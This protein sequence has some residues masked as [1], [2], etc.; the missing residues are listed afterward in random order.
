VR[1]LAP[2]LL[3]SA[4][5]AA[6]QDPVQKTAAPDEATQKTALAMIADVYKPDYEKAKSAPQKVELAKKLLGVGVATEDDPTSRF[7]LF[8]IARDIASQQ[9]DLSTA[10]DA[11]RHIEL[12]FIADTLQMKVDAATVALKSLETPRD[13]LSC[14]VLL[15]AQLDD[16]VFADRYEL[17]KSLASSMLKCARN[18]RDAECIKQAVAIVKMLDD[19]AAEYEKVR[20]AKTA[21]DEQPA[22]PAANFALATFFC[23]VKGNW[24]R[25]V[26]MFALGAN[27]E[28]KAAA[29]LELEAK[30]DSVK[31]GDAWWRIA[32]GLEGT[33]KSKTQIHAVAWYRRALPQLS[34]FSKERVERLIAQEPSGPDSLKIRLTPSAT[35]IEKWI[36]GTFDVVW[37]ES[38]TGKSGT[39]RCTYDSKGGVFRGSERNGT[40]KLK[41]DAIEIQFADPSR[42]RALVKPIDA[43][44][45]TGTHRMGDGN[46][47]TWTGKRVK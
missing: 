12:A 13:H 10:F 33:A 19:I 3:M 35:E 8:R 14:A 29:L 18:S 43:N 23:F 11:I 25:G 22:D 32:E 36:V 27:E 26:P 20:G 16:A 37:S 6:A 38:K 4:T 45:Y 5:L 46:V 34:G 2:I 15:S 1:L 31:V 44:N 47:S 39:L 30:P 9:G 24:R 7:V 28:I 42:G 17:A 21:L 40:W 41:G